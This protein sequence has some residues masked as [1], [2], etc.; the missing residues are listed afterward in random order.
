VLV[1]GALA[2]T[3]TAS[4]AGGDLLVFGGKNHKVF[5][6]CLTCS[7]YDTDSVLNQYG[8]YGSRYSS[9]SIMNQYSDYGSKYSTYSA[10]NPYASDPPIVTDGEG[11]YYGKLTLNKY[12]SDAITNTTI[13]VWLSGVCSSR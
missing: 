2:L 10:C 11:G 8:S 7:Q 1:A 12:A 5:I 3:L 13:V 4:A 6:G 9:T